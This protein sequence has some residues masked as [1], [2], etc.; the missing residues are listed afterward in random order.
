MQGIHG[1]R[2]GFNDAGYTQISVTVK[3]EMVYR[4]RKAL[5]PAL[6]FDILIFI[7][8]QVFSAAI[9]PRRGGQCSPLER[10]LRQVS[11]ENKP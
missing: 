11:A 1:S 5:H 6:N 4:H 7:P 8:N 10:D 3:G 9:P 2:H